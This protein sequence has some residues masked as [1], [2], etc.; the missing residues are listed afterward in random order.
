MSR[1]AGSLRLEISAA[2]SAHFTAAAPSRI[3]YA[4]VQPLYQPAAVPPAEGGSAPA[5]AP[6]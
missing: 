6:R 5:E 2:F 4:I 1:I 3:D